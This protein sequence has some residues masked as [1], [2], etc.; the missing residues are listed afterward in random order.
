MVR[1]QVRLIDDLLVN[2]L[3]KPLGFCDPGVITLAPAAGTGTYLLG[4]IDH[5]LRRIEAEQGAGAVAGQATAL[6]RNLYSFELMVGP[7][8][9]TELRVSRALRD[10]G[11]ALPSGGTHVYLT[12]TLESPHAEPPQLPLFLRPIAEQHAKALRIK[13]SVPVIVCVGNPPYDRHEAA[14]GDNKARTGGWVRWGD[15][16]KGEDAIL[17][18]F[19]DPAIT[20]GHGVHLKWLYNLYVYFWRWALWK[21]FEHETSHGPGVVS[22]ITASS[23]LF[24]DAFVGMREHM[25]RVCDEIWI[26]D[27]GGEGRGARKHENVFAIQTPVS[28]A[29]A[30]RYSNANKNNPATVRYARIEGTRADKLAAL[31][32]IAGFASV[33]W[34][35]CPD[36]WHAPFLPLG[37]GG[38]FNWPIIRDLFPWQ[39]SGSQLF[40]TWP[41]APDTHTLK[42]RWHSLL[43]AD[44]R[45]K[46]FKE[47]RDRKINRGY[48]PLLDR[49]KKGKA[50]GELES[51]TPPRHRS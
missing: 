18:G 19:L 50:L 46:A 48:R 24:G 6:A 49:Q 1:C 29:V 40:R 12:D 22:F 25:R 21:V 2:R 45:A 34:T 8:A 13:S 36:D 28:I 27:L 11:A 37:E 26:L 47:S 39:H 41:I 35:T 23:Y 30:I 16:D 38:Y 9:V 31:Y 4:V 32:A 5:A 43:V 51:S 20:A 33:E 14:T 17:R 42:R 15:G 7:Y 3:G 44:D 10:H